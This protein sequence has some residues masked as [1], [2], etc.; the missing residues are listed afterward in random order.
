MLVSCPECNHRISDKALTCPNCGFPYA[1]NEVNVADFNISVELIDK[2]QIK[3]LHPD[4]LSNIKV[5]VCGKDEKCTASVH[6]GEQL[7]C[8]LELEKNTF[9]IQPLH[10]IRGSS[11]YTVLHKGVSEIKIILKLRAT[12]RYIDRG[13]IDRFGDIIPT[14]VKEPEYD[15]QFV[16]INLK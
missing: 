15:I 12:G 14:G 3:L 11:T 7:N 13:R 4:E 1:N 16:R 6:L 8:T 9:E 5:F 2:A 10:R